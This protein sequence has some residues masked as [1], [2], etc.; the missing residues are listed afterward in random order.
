M[1][2]RLLVKLVKLLLVG[3][4]IVFS[5]GITTLAQTQVQVTAVLKTLANPFW[6]VMQQ[7]LLEEA[8]KEVDQD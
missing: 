1:K 8:I 4:F 7:G 3:L 5:L 6:V 2:D